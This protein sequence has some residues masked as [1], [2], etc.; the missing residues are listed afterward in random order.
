MKQ[1]LSSLWIFLHAALAA[2]GG[3][4]LAFG[5]LELSPLATALVAL[6][7][8]LSVGVLWTWALREARRI[9]LL[10]AFTLAFLLALGALSLIQ[11]RGAGQIWVSTANRQQNFAQLCAVMR[12]HYPYFE[13]KN[14]DWDSACR[15]YLP[16]VEA[17]QTDSEYHALI[18]RMLAELGDAHT[19]LLRPR[20]AD[21]RFYFG[22]ALALADGVALD[23]EGFIAQTAGLRRGAE[24]LAVNGVAAEE[25]LL[26]LPLPLRA[27]STPWQSR[28]WAAF[29]LLSAPEKSLTVTYRNPGEEARTVTLRWKDEKPLPQNASG[30]IIA[31][32]ILPSGWGL[33]RLPTFSHHASQNLTAEFDR[34]L[35]QTRNASGLILDLRGNGGGDSRLAE[36]I[37]GRFFSER[38]CYG[39]DRFRHR[40]PQRG[41][42]LRFEYCVEPRGETITLP[43]VLL[44][45]SRNMSS[46]EQFIAIFTESGRALTVGER[47]GGASG[48]PLAFPL[49]GGGQ[50]RF[51]AGAFYTRSGLLIEGNGIQP[52]VPVTFTLADFQQGR[53]PALLAAQQIRSTQLSQSQSP[54]SQKSSPMFYVKLF[55]YFLA[56]A[57]FFTS[58][59]MALMGA[60]WQAVEQSA[61]A[62]ERRPWWFVTASVL[63]IGFYLFALYHFIGAAPKTWAGWLLMVILPLGWGLKA[64]LVVFNPKGRAAVSA[65]EG[66]QNWRKVALARLPI[67]LLLGV[68]TWFA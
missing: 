47:T 49:P 43:L 50:I 64:A 61:Y 22:T 59:A 17:A 33:I 37:A 21:S 60:R 28:A 19:G 12:A 44:M 66:D 8:A 63:L 41:W 6:T 11:M 67:A 35:E 31:A 15:H 65:I 25:A 52:D 39:Q 7:F 20:P 3:G 9:R 32:Q 4:T 24:I 45:D 13:Q 40:L 46:A 27:G 16:L 30:T 42:S 68:L 48:N 58:L 51:S 36:Q 2:L 18:A 62:S 54:N 10:G 34:A 1:L 26:N 56:S 38:F 53:D 14:V 5:I 23:Q 29:H 55:G 57:A